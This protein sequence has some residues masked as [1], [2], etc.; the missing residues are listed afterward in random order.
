MGDKV[1]DGVKQASSIIDS[2]TKDP[3]LVGEGKAKEKNEKKWRKNE[4]I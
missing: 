4:N 3:K 1:K 2:M